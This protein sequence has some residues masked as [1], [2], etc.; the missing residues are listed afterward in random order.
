[1]LQIDAQP[2]RLQ[3]NPQRK[4]VH[5]A[6]VLRPLRELVLVRLEFLLELAHAGCV[7]VEED[8]AVGGF[9]AVE[10]RLGLGEDVGWEEIFVYGCDGVPEVVVIFFEEDDETGGLRVE[11]AGDVFDCVG[12]DFFDAGVGDGR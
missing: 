4:L 6:R 7:L 3:R 10:A 2:L 1:M 12:Y 9:E 8:G 5:P 11:G